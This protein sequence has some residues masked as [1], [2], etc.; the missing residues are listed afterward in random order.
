LVIED[1]RRKGTDMTSLIT[2]ISAQRSEELRNYAASRRRANRARRRQTRSAGSAAVAERVALR[3][4][5]PVGDREALERLAG[6]DSA[7]VPGGAVLGAELDG[8]LVAALSLDT[9]SLVADPFTPTEAVV[10]R[11]RERADR[12]RDGGHRRIA[13][14]HGFHLTARPHRG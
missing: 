5:H 14:R 9:G 12:L 11:L 7:P 4:L 8:R 6:R 3:R 1:K 2:T 10:E 13:R